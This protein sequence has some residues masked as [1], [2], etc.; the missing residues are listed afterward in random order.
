MDILKSS[1]RMCEMECMVP[2]NWASFLI[3]ILSGPDALLVSKA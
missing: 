3:Y 1:D 2:L